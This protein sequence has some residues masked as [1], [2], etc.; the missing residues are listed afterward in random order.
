M[1]DVVAYPIV[2]QS[3]IAVFLFGFE[4]AGALVLVEDV[5]SKLP[6]VSFGHGDNV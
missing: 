5:G 4:A 6:A 1:N 3:F 2:L